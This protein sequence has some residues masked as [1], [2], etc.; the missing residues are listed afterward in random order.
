[1]LNAFVDESCRQRAGEDTAVYVL[2][3]VLVPDQALATVRETMESLRFGKAPTVHWR[4]ER[5]ERRL[6]I[7]QALAVLEVDGLVAVCLHAQATRSERARRKCLELLLTELSV[8]GVGRVVLESRRAQDAGD[9]AILTALR[10]S[11]RVR[12]DMEV[13]WQPPGPYPELWAADVVAGVVTWWLDGHDQ[14]L[15]LLGERLTVLD[16][17]E[18]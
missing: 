6:L 2:A 18:T 13:S 16:V 17:D 3:A 1:M 12:L 14:Y 15:P 8:R 5:N 9:R 10:T 4:T 11:R 7:T